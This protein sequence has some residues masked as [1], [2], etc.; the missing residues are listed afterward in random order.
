V[1]TGFCCLGSKIYIIGGAD[2]TGISKAVEIFDVQTN[3]W[4]LGAGLPTPSAELVVAEVN[5]KI[6]AIGG[7]NLVATSFVYEYD[8]LT[9]A[10]TTKAPMTTARSVMSGCVYNNKIYVAGGWPGTKNILEIYDPATNSWSTGAP[11]PAGRHN[12][13]SMVALN[14]KI[15]FIGGKNA[16]F[17]EV[18]NSVFIYDPNL[19]TWSI[20]PSLPEPRYHGVAF[21]DGKKI[22][23]A[24]GSPLPSNS[25]GIGSYKGAKQTIFE[26]DPLT[27]SWTTSGVELPVPRMYYAGIFY[28]NRFYAFGG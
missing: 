14:G 11:M 9:N 1:G 7:Y 27:N 21:T 3:S 15:Y 12:I 13:N 25:V 20:R 6:Y 28:Q 10:W 22:Y 8:P 17:S 19:N 5:G 26:L 2:S 23:Y 24:E 4:T 16:L 18:Y